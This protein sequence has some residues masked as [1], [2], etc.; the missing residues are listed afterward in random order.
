MTMSG[1]RDASVAL[2][3]HY[4][5]KP[6]RL[7]P[8]GLWVRLERLGSA[9]VGVDAIALLSSAMAGTISLRGQH[10]LDLHGRRLEQLEAS[11]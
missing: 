7:D 5:P 10:A 6:P 1:Q 9:A 11:T 4:A 8:L 2:L 3:R